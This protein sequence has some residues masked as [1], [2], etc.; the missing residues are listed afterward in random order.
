M[1]M[2]AAILLLT[3]TTGCQMSMSGVS[4][5]KENCKAKIGWVTQDIVFNPEDRINNDPF[6]ILEQE[7]KEIRFD[8]EQGVF[9]GFSVIKKF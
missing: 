1:R 2:I 6:P 7:R 3:M 4:F 8:D 5:E 9:V